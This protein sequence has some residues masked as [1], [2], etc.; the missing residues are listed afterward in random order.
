MFKEYVESDEWIGE[1][2]AYNIYQK[3][4]AFI[5]SNNGCFFNIIGVP[6]YKIIHLIRKLMFN[7]EKRKSIAA[8]REI[9][10]K[11]T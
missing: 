11:T 6:I 10:Q 7:G 8:E 5:E 2:A 4:G 1:F 3:G 9:L